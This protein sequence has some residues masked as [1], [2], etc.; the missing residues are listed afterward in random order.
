MFVSRNAIVKKLFWKI[1]RYFSPDIEVGVYEPIIITDKRAG[2]ELPLEELNELRNRL[3]R[4]HRWYSRN[5]QMK[6]GDF[7]YG[8][9][10]II[11]FVN[12]NGKSVKIGK[13][14]SIASG[15]KI[16]LGGGHTVDWVTTYPFYDFLN[17]YRYKQRDV[18]SKTDDVIIGNDV[19]IGKDVTI[20]SGAKIGDGCIIGTAALVT[21]NK[22]LPDYTIWGGVPA[23]QIGTRFPSDVIESLKKIKWWDW[24]DGKICNAIPL[25]LN[26]DIAALIEYHKG[27]FK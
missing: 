11:L 17:F 9:P 23:K 4:G 2:Q 12:H 21:Q 8:Y 5:S 20:M 26:N 15:V 19:W 14:C 24:P 25:L 27:V 3:R 6:I 22:H 7:T 1:W 13:F 18:L 16:F 10:K